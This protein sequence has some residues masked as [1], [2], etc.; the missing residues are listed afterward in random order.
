M[1]KNNDLD[2]DKLLLQLQLLQEQNQQ[3]VLQLQQKPT[4]GRAIDQYAL[5]AT[6]LELTNNITKLYAVYMLLSLYFYVEPYRTEIDNYIN[7]I[8]LE[9]KVPNIKNAASLTS[10]V[11]KTLNL[12]KK[13]DQ[14]SSDIIYKSDDQIFD[15]EPF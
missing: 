10:R 15:G 4:S 13:Q 8:E 14:E 5:N 12:T 3:L 7:K 9:G 11:I 1:S 6:N 2:V